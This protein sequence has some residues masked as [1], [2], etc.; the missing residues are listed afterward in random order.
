MPLVLEGPVCLAESLNPPG[1]CTRTSTSALGISV[2]F[3][4][5]R[6][7]LPGVLACTPCGVG[8]TCV[9]ALP[10]KQARPSEQRRSFRK[11]RVTCCTRATPGVSLSHKHKGTKKTTQRASGERG[12]IPSKA[13][14]ELPTPMVRKRHRARHKGLQPIGSHQQA[15][16]PRRPMINAGV[17]LATTCSTQRPEVD[18]S[19]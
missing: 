4:L 8:C 3:A 6:C 15:S 14:Q 17:G 12:F 9:Q 5:I 16:S 13:V 2:P 19:A 18:G 11:L 7:R 10:L 1:R